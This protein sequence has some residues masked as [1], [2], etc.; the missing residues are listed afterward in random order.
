MTLTSC[1]N[2]ILWRGKHGEEIFILCRLQIRNVG[3]EKC[4]SVVRIHPGSRTRSVYINL[5]CRHVVHGAN[6]L[7]ACCLT[8]ALRQSRVAGSWLDIC[9]TSPSALWHQAPIRLSI[10]KTQRRNV[11][12]LSI[13]SPC[14]YLLDSKMLSWGWFMAAKGNL[15][16]GLRK[17]W[18]MLSSLQVLMV[19]WRQ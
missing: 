16:S 2:P 5:I 10:I 14:C 8:I 7:T 11:P 3:F 13:F 1:Q 4:D 17:T 18:I 6:G 19:L 15:R 12:L 9:S